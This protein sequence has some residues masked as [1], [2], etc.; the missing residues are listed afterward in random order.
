VIFAGARVAH[1]A[2]VA[3]VAGFYMQFGKPYEVKQGLT[4]N[5]PVDLLDEKLAVAEPPLGCDKTENGGWLGPGRVS[6]EA[7]G[8]SV[9]AIIPYVET[10]DQH[11]FIT[12]KPYLET[13]V[14]H[15]FIM[16]TNIPYVFVNNELLH[17]L[18]IY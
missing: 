6:I 4:R 3:P 13:C 12:D 8:R 17:S 18:F 14:T 1:D 7:H 10:C 2:P 16:N 9:S 15:C 11:R 5:M